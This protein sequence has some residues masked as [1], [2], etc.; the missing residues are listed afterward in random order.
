M[1]GSIV[2]HYANYD[3]YM[4]YELHSML[5]CAVSKTTGEKV[6]PAYGGG[7]ESFLTNIVTPLYGVIH[8]EAMKNR[9]GT[10]DHSTW[11]NYDDLNEY[12]WSPECFHIG[13]PMRLDHDFFCVQCSNDRKVTKSRL[14][15]GALKRRHNYT[16]FF[17]DCPTSLMDV[18]ASSVLPF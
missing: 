2:M 5:I 9:N 1:Y 14:L 11:R 6:M 12:F 4:A 8:E 16:I 3:K 17:T 7:P 13:W 15:I 18:N 10:T